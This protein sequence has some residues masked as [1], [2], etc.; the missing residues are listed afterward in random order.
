MGP[1]D[2]L[3]DDIFL[4]AELERLPMPEPEED[5]YTDI[6]QDEGGEG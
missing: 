3:I 5:D 2:K 4:I 6:W 1:K